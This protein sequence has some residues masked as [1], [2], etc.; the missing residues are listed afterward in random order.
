MVV[1]LIVQCGSSQDYSES[2]VYGEKLIMR[3]LESGR[4]KLPWIRSFP[5]DEDQR[6]LIL[7]VNFPSVL[8]DI[9]FLDLLREGFAQ[10]LPF[11]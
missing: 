9:T 6:N 10:E 1:E 2:Q 7:I 8:E 3:H 5:G 11:N 4:N